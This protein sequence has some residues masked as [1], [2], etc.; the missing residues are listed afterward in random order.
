MQAALKLRNG[1]ATASPWRG[2]RA[3]AARPADTPDKRAAMSG[4]RMR[5]LAVINREEVVPSTVAPCRDVAFINA[6]VND[7]SVRPFIGPAELGEIDL[8]EAIARPENL[9]L[10]GQHGGFVLAWSAPGVHE[11]HTFITEAGRGTWARKARYETIQYCRKRGVHMLWTKI[12]LDTPHVA[13]FAAEAGM[14]PTGQVV[15]TFDEPW[16]IY[17]MEL[18]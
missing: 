5:Q 13:K 14:R 1:Y 2:L 4:N 3:Q 15:E 11:V 18:A 7:P 16:L 12:S 10:M 9:C 6:V 8:S 17:K